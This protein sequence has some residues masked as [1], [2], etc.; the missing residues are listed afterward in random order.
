VAHC[1]AAGCVLTTVI[2]V[3]EVVRAIWSVCFWRWL[4]HIQM[5]TCGLLP[6]HE[7]MA[8]QGAGKQDQWRAYMTVHVINHRKIQSISIL[9]AVIR[10]IMIFDVD[11]PQD[12]FRQEVK[13]T[14]V[15]GGQLSTI[16]GLDLDR[17][18]PL[19]YTLLQEKDTYCLPGGNQ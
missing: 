3:V 2:R 16:S 14:L 1:S 5:N 19:P 7:S 9:T 11:T 13:W 6:L 4:G 17:V 8:L 10:L 18:H 12:C 15:I